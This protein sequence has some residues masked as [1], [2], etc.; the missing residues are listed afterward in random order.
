M[1][2][3]C[4]CAGT[5]KVGQA[6][7]GAVDHVC[8]IPAELRAGIENLLGEITD[9]VDENLAL[10]TLWLDESIELHAMHK[11]N[12]IAVRSGVMNAAANLRRL[13]GESDGR[14]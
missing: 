11:D 14:A 4:L 8:T 5:G 1:R 3:C 2:R 12:L 6:Q 10:S 13:L 9:K 7:T